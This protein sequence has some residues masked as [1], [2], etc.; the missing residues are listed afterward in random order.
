M[1]VQTKESEVIISKL[2]ESA[3]KI[4]QI[5][6]EE[7][8]QADLNATVSENVIKAI[9]DEQIHRLILPKEYGYPRN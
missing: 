7:S 5:A 4:G 3:I 8:V 1:T 2:I 9:K 6:E